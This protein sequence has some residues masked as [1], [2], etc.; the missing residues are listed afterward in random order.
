M[1]ARQAPVSSRAGR[2]RVVDR[3]AAHTS[4]AAG[5]LR[6]HLGGKAAQRG[7]QQGQPGDA[8]SRQRRP[9]RA[10]RVASRPHRHGQQ[11]AGEFRSPARMGE[12]RAGQGY[13]AAIPKTVQ[14]WRVTMM[15]TLTLTLYCIAI[16][17]QHR[18]RLLAPSWRIGVSGV[19]WQPAP[20]RM[21]G[22]GA[23][24]LHVLSCG[25]FARQGIQSY[26][27]A[28]IANKLRKTPV[29]YTHGMT[30]IKVSRCLAPKHIARLGYTA[31]FLLLWASPCLLP[32]LPLS[33]RPEHRL[34]ASAR[35]RRPPAG[36][37]DEPGLPLLVLTADAQAAQRLKEEIPVFAPPRA[38][39]CA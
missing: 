38:C 14:P 27:Y 25:R 37:P 3:L 17:A 36:R 16:L 33:S 11:G 18:P 2:W 31:S 7:I 8:P 32:C 28:P 39:C 30:W 26:R 1:R 22:R 13:T 23:M 29:I 24:M 4:Q 35:R 6:I 15:S 21:C 34:G 10:V 19:F 5:R 20:L 12:A 9:W